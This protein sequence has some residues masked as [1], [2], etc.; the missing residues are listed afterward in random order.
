VDQGAQHAHTAGADGVTQGN[1]P[2]ID[3]YFG[4]M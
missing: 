4:P 1:R 3:V 2:A